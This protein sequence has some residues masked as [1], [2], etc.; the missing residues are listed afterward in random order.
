MRRLPEPLDWLM[1]QRLLKS[2]PASTA[3]VAAAMR[4]NKG[5]NTRPELLV[6]RL[7]HRLGYR[8]RTHLRSVPGRPD[9]AFPAR[10]K[11]VQV[12]G[13]FWHQHNDPSCSLRMH[14]RSNR[15][16]WDA[17][18]ARNV[19]RDAE[20]LAALKAAGWQ[21]LTL[22]ECNCRDEVSLAQRLADFLGPTRLIRPGAPIRQSMH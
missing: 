21:V 18:L 10:R 7:L 20:Q 5:A 2:P 19:V 22:W 12:H 3:A 11:V 14:P 1:A 13:C 9:V 4:G 16:Y 15:S 17:K 8:F 6:R